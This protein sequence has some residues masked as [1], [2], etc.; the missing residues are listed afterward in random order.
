MP[1]DVTESA[2][3]AED[4]LRKESESQADDDTQL[5][6]EHEQFLANPKLKAA[7]DSLTGASDDAAKADEPEEK[8]DDNEDQ[9]EEKSEDAPAGST[10]PA[11]KTE[12][13][14]QESEPEPEKPKAKAPAAERAQDSDADPD[15]KEVAGFSHGAQRRIQELVRKRKTIEKERD[16]AKKKAAYREELDARLTEAGM[17]R[18]AWDD[19]VKLGFAIQT[20][21][22]AA[23]KTL[24]ALAKG[25]GHSETAGEGAAIDID[26]DLKELVDNDEMT[27]VAAKKV[28]ATRQRRPAN[29]PQAR[30]A[31][32]P[33]SLSPRAETGVQIMTRL[34]A[35][36][37]KSYP[38]QWDKLAAEVNTELTAYRGVPL[39]VWERTIRDAVGRVVARKN[40]R[41]APPD[42]VARGNS[43]G[44]SSTVS[45]GNKPPT[46]DSVVAGFSFIRKSR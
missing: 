33:P 5:S 15:P 17:S 38:D 6:P 31:S 18:D 21:P 28:Q 24:G 30:E 25:L 22:A 42:P 10:E 26:A 46:K 36:Y 12:D 29:A 34:D 11:E 44:R 41:A 20:N 8:S 27:E 45:Q 4:D 35:E 13:E 7:L 40:V 16:E 14:T 9:P 3:S 23:A 1:S 32:A 39:H 19:W 43:G 37:A 2:S